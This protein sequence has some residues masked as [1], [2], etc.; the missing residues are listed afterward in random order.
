MGILRGLNLDQHLP[1]GNNLAR[2]DQ[3]SFYHTIHVGSNSLL[4]FHGFEGN[5]WIPYLDR[6]AFRNQDTQ[7]LAG[8]R[9]V[10]GLLRSGAGTSRI[11]RQPRDCTLDKDA[12]YEVLLALRANVELA[13][14]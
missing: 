6:L 1:R 2:L 7:H 9:R 14:N 5:K 4:H 8:H 10:G 11:T 12:M 13:S 3:D